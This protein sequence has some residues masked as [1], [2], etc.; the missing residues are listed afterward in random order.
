MD[1]KTQPYWAESE[2]A[3]NR[4]LISFLFATLFFPAFAEEPRSE[5]ERFFIGKLW[6]HELSRYVYPPSGHECTNLGGHSLSKDQKSLDG[7]SINTFMCDGREL[8]IFSADAKST[9]VAWTLST[10]RILDAVLL[11]RLKK[12]EERMRAGDCELNGN[13]N[14]DFIAIVHLGKRDEVNW[15]TGVRAAWYPNPETRKI[16]RLSTRNIICYRPTPP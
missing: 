5:F 16:E 3:M 12:G 13:A 4:L 2:L 9:Q 7:F 1:E 11:P 14:T 10:V 15:K 8:V 6:A